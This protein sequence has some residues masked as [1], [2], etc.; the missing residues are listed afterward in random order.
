MTNYYGTPG[1]LEVYKE[2]EKKVYLPKCKH[3]VSVKQLPYGQW[4]I[5]R[6]RA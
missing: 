6:R 3:I 1:T 2:G 5:A 4:L